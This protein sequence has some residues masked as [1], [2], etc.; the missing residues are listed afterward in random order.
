M[1]SP[2]CMGFLWVL[3]IPATVQTPA[4]E[5]RW[6]LLIAPKCECVHEWLFISVSANLARGGSTF[7]ATLNKKWYR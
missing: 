3:R 2:S 6:L 5:V 4:D 7:L 1:F